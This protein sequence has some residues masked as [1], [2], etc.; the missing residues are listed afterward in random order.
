LSPATGASTQSYISSLTSTSQSAVVCKYFSEQEFNDS[1]KQFAENSPQLSLFHLNIRSL[2]A[3]CFKLQQ[4]LIS[5]EIDFDVIVL[6]EIWSFNITMYE[7]LL[8]NYKFYYVLPN[9]SSIGGIGAYV[10]S[11]FSV[12]VLNDLFLNL[13]VNNYAIESLFLELS[14]GD[15]RCILS[16]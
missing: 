5:L 3:N 14:R 6:S 7:S 10:H 9:N 4:L 15:Y 2:N 1:C 16:T 11:S 8:P 13:N 12:S